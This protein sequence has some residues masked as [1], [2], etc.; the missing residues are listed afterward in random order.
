MGFDKAPLVDAHVHLH[1]D[2]SMAEE[3]DIVVAVSDDL[4]SSLKTLKLPAIKCVG[5]HPWSIENSSERDLMEV[6]R[7]APEADCLGEVGLDNRYVKDREKMKRFFETF[8]TLSREYDLPLNLHALDAWREVFE[9]LL[10]FDVKR[11]Y[12]HWYNGP[13]DLIEEIAGQGY[14]IGIN[15]AITIQKKHLKVLKAAPL[16]AILTESDGPYNY[17]GTT[18]RPREVGKLIEIISREKNVT[19]VKELV[20][21]NLVRWLGKVPRIGGP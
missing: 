16:N 7:L 18:L 12:F 1:E 20:F 6:G 15:A 11:A 5:I 21:R 9:L 13:L 10:K 14:F 8:L 17:R 3:A 2:P 4:S 19:E